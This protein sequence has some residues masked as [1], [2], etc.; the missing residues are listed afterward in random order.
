[1]RAD[2]FPVMG[3]DAQVYVVGGPAQLLV[4][5]RTRTE[6]LEGLWSRFLPGSE[7]SQLNDTAGA[8]PRPVSPETFE[9]IQRGVQAWRMTGGLF[10]PTVLGDVLRAGYTTSF[11]YL[12]RQRA[13]RSP[14]PAL[15][16]GAGDIELDPRT[17]TVLLPQGVGFDPGGIGKGL[18]ADLV[19]AELLAA[20]ADGVCVNLGGDVRAAGTPPE[21]SW[22]IAI[23]HPTRSAPAA[24]AQ[25][26]DGA[27]A[28]SSRLHRRWDTGR[29]PAHHL[30]DPELGAPS[31]TTLW[32]ATAIAAKGWQAEAFAKAAFLAGPS[33]LPVLE[34][35][36]IAVLLIDEG[37]EVLTNRLVSQFLDRSSER[38]ALTEVMA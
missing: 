35:V 7:L 15:T 21:E 38:L 10:D 27:V 33:G 16:R 20:G 23:E 36:G 17:R 6:D 2:A 24:V 4:R 13:L 1:M 31:D 5:A 37:G 8:G 9:L 32:T 11:E 19:V 12:P 3:S 30:I 28:T 18:A 14:G 25:L 29:G 22:A 34:R 26:Q